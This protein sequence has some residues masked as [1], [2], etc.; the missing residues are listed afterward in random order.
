[1]LFLPEYFRRF[2]MRICATVVPFIL[3]LYSASND[4]VAIYEQMANSAVIYAYRYACESVW[5]HDSLCD[6]WSPRCGILRL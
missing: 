6:A 2:I 3:T 1:M 5:H 4:A